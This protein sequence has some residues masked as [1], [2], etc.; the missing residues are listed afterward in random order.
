MTGEEV[1]LSDMLECREKRVA[2]QNAFRENCQ[3]PIL[4]FCMNIPGP[5]KTN[6]KIR[7]A[8]EQGKKEILHMF[9]K[10]SIPILEYM[11]LHEKTGDELILAFDA[12]ASFI[13]ALATEIEN[14]HPLGRLFDID[15]ISENGHKLSRS[16]F[17]KCLI[18]NAQAQEC[19]SS[20]R[21]AT[22][23]MQDK[24]DEI[25]EAL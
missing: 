17:R 24:I 25:L 11:E 20:R 8:F 16:A 23:E 4:S 18:C 5:I 15:I 19:A 10:Y 3:K 7:A 22:K 21:H 9:Q 13:K 12:S 6:S 1:F 14:V 2:I